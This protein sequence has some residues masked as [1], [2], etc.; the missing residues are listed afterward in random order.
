M[1]STKP[2]QWDAF[3]AQPRPPQLALFDL[4]GVLAN[5]VHRQHHALARQWNE[6][7]ALMGKD[8]VWP[9]GRELYDNATLLE[10]DVMYLT[11][12]R[13]DTRAMTRKWLKKKGFDHKLP[14]IMRPREERMPLAVLKAG[15]VAGLTSHYPTVL[16]YDDDPAVIDAV[17][18][19][20][21]HCTWHIKPERMVRR[22][23][24]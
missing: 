17:G 2:D 21:R 16:L 14:L 6:Y 4:D 1:P 7:F 5:D 11:G 10:W 12:R 3:F 20:G 19:H 15:I 9:Q 18:D 23:R 13:E 8:K 24:S 22:A